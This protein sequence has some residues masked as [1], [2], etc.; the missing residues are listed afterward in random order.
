[1]SL[2]ELVVNEK[3]SYACPIIATTVMKA[4]HMVPKKIAMWL[5]YLQ[6]KLRVT[7]YWKS[8]IFRIEKK[9]SGYNETST[10]VL[11]WEL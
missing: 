5:K 7:G 10:N 11:N 1:V 8:C 3:I 6:P 4:S 9:L 2:Y